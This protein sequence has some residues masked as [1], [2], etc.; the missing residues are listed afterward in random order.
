MTRAK[1][2]AKGKKEEREREEKQ[3][4]CE[5]VSSTIAGPLGTLLLFFLIL[6]GIPL[7]GFSFLSEFFLFFAYREGGTSFEFMNSISEYSCYSWA[8]TRKCQKRV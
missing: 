1:A 8:A 7:F 3:N 4:Y 6:F 2:K 5:P